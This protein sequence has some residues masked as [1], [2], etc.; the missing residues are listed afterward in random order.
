[1]DQDQAPRKS[2]TEITVRS[3]TLDL[4]GQ[5]SNAKFLE[6]LEEARWNHFEGFFESGMFLDLDLAFMLVHVDLNYRD[7]AYLGDILDIE[8]WISRIGNKSI[9]LSQTITNRPDGRL[10]IEGAVTFVVKDLKKGVAVP[11]TGRMRD[12]FLRER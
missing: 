8:T 2:K 5:V 3:W 9:T 4:Y 10:I 12:M 1:M 7:G 11:I 6:F